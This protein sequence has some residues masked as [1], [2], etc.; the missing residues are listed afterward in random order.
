VGMPW[1]V[2]DRDEE[3]GEGK[4]GTP[5]P[6]ITLRDP[7]QKDLSVNLLRQRP[8]LKE[9]RGNHVD[10]RV[11]RKGS[12]GGGGKAVGGKKDGESRTATQLPRIIVQSKGDLMHLNVGEAIRISV[13]QKDR[14]G[15]HTFCNIYDILPLARSFGEETGGFWPEGGAWRCRR[16]G[17]SIIG[18]ACLW[19]A[20]P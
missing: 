9:R 16:D 5:S 2:T 20:Y 19:E 15:I 4:S 1:F 11:R 8:Y 18:G 17:R 13:P 6:R 7:F 14:G 12:L 10:A 3:G